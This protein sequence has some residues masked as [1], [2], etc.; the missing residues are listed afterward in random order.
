MAVGIIIANATVY[1]ATTGSDTAGNGLVGSPFATVSHALAFLA[2]FAIAPGVVITINVANGTY[3]DNPVVSHPNG[4]Q[5]EIVGNSG[6][7]P[8]IIAATHIT[9][10]GSAN[11]VLTFASVAAFTPAGG[12]CVVFHTGTGTNHEYLCSAWL[13]TAVNGGANTVTINTSGAD[14]QVVPAHPADG[15]LNGVL[16]KTFLGTITIQTALRRI[17]ACAAANLVML[18]GSRCG[19]DLHQPGSSTSLLAVTGANI[20]V[21]MGAGSVLEIG[22][23]AVSKCTGEGLEL[24]PGATLFAGYLLISQCTND[25]GIW[26]AGSIAVY[27]IFQVTCCVYGFEAFGG[28]S[29]LTGF[30]ALGSLV[31]NMSGNN[32]AVYLPDP[33][34][35]INLPGL[36]LANNQVNPTI[37]TILSGN[38]YVAVNY[39]PLY[40]HS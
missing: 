27:Q 3:A 12:D 24:D 26:S 19:F 10:D 14:Q 8:T 18:P 21:K 34:C 36:T 25:C 28:A 31:A 2:G 13:T 7:A 11:V 9:A 33:T 38:S 29:T 16:I 35:Q 4:S 20:G 37:D 39:T 30:G 6:S 22:K 5:I 17:Q 40:A 32:S 15:T 23:L 1:V